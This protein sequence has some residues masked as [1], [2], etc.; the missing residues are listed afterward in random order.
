MSNLKRKGKYSDPLAQLQITWLPLDMV[1]HDLVA[2]KIEQKDN[3]E[4]VRTSFIYATG[5]FIL[6]PANEPYR[7]NFQSIFTDEKR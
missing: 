2:N 7:R 6:K 4:T 5:V 3:V 1:Q